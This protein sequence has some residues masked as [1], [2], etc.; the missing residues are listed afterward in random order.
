MSLA[1]THGQFVISEFMANNLSSAEV[2]EDT[3]HSDWIE[4]QNNGPTTASLNGW[5]LTDD[6]TELRKWQFPLTTPAVSV[7]GGGRIT[8][9]ASSK[10]RKASATRLH[11]NFK[12]NNTGEFLALVRPDGTTIEHSYSPAYP[13]QI[14]S[15]TYGLGNVLTTK[16]LLPEISPGRAK[17]P[18]SASDFSLNFNN[19]R[20]ATFDDTSWQAGTA[21]F[22][23]G[24]PFTSQLGS[25]GNI[26]GMM[27]GLNAS[28]FIRYKF[29]YTPTFPVAAMRLIMRWDDGFSS[30]LNG[31]FVLKNGGALI[32]AW[33][34][35]ALSARDDTTSATTLAANTGIP[36]LVSGTNLLGFQLFNSA[37]TEFN[38]SN[39]VTNA[40]L[41]AQLEIDEI[42]SIASGYLSA[43][44]RGAANANL[45]TTIGPAISNTTDKPP[46]PTGGATSA[47]MLITTTVNPT[48]RPLAPSNP[49][50]LRW[51][52]MFATESSVTMMDDGTNGD[53]TA[54]DKIYTASIPTTSLLPGEMIRWRIVAQDNSASPIYAYDPPYPGFSSTA[55][56]TNPPPVDAFMEAE[57]YFGTIALPALVGNTS[58]P[59][60]HWYFT[61][62][63][64]TVNGNGTRCSF[65]WQPLPLDQPPAG[66]VPPKPRFYD[67]VLVNIHGQSSQ[68]FPKKSHDLSFSK[69]N[70]FLWKDGTPET[71]GVNLLSNYADKSKVRDSTAY[72]VWEKSQ[73][74]ASHYATLVRVQQ[75]NAF[76][77]L[78]DLVENGNA[79]WLKR[80]H[81]DEAGTL[82]KIYN[83]LES[84]AGNEKKNPDDT[85][86]T[87]LNALVAGINP[88]LPLTNRL[89][90]LYDNVNVAALINCMATHSI[91]LNRDF[92]HKNYYVYRDTHGTQEWSVLPWDQ[93]LCLGH[94]WTGE[95]G[96]FDDN[97]HSQAALQPIN[98]GVPGNRLM[99]LVYDTPELNH[100]F[101]RRLRTLADHFYV[102]P[103]ETNGPIAQH[104][105]AIIQQIDPDPN[106]TATGLD[107]ADLDSRAWG[108]WVDGSG[109][110]IPYTDSRMAE[111]TA[112]VQ[113]ARITISNPVPPNPGG[114]YNDGTAS[115]FPFLLGRR[116][117]YFSAIPPISPSLNG[118]TLPNQ[119]FPTSQPAEPNV[120][121]EQFNVTPTTGNYQD[122]E[123][124]VI[125]N[126][127]AFAVDLSGW[128]L[129]GDIKLIFQGGTII[130]AQG[131]A[132]TQPENAAYVNEL[133][134]ANQPAGFRTRSTAPMANQYR[135]VAGPYEHQLSAYGGTITLSRP[136][137]PLNPSAGYTQ[138]QSVTYTGVPTDA[139]KY[140]RITELNFRPAPATTQ[141]LAQLPGLVSGDFEFIELLNT[142]EQP[143]DLGGTYF[144]EGVEFTFPKPFLL[145][146][147]QRCVLVASETAF[148]IRYGSSHLVAG[149]F[150][151]ALDNGGETLRLLDSVGEAVLEF[152]YDDDWYPVPT[153]QYRSFVIA[154]PMP[155]ATAYSQPASW[156][157]SANTN[158]S[159]SAGDTTSS[160]VY[161]G[162]RHAF[163][164]N[165]LTN[166]AA[167]PTADP[168]G[169]GWTNFS[170]YAFGSN[171]IDASS[172]PQVRSGSAN[173]GAD[174]F[175]TIT[176]QRPLNTI[177]TVYQGQATSDLANGPWV[178]DAVLLT[179]AVALSNGLE[180]VTFRD[181]ISLTT[182]PT[183]FLRCSCSQ[184]VNP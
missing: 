34:S 14:P 121:L 160:I 37:A 22:G 73:H 25:G 125:R 59:V 87:E 55:L 68:G 169:D 88:S 156:A 96:Y 60:L 146:P 128:K 92:G 69:D 173:I 98:S 181:T 89:K 163:F 112:R 153:G 179:P 124:F 108:F 27:R 49:V 131:A 104:I 1:T 172:V 122:Q 19:W 152:T 83:S 28:C 63:D 12:L 166:P 145:N 53:V 72:W 134:V 42:T 158:G 164:A 132:T 36:F 157:L 184:P 5:Y 3:S 67:N 43:S 79:S 66:Y 99:Q 16:V 177:D 80:Q 65:F 142:G 93:D 105:D 23:F 57:Q 101:V 178:P 127:N 41:K 81:L 32:P 91:I 75:N 30:Y 111:Q 130:P 17:S 167:P 180:E 118:T 39:D 103:A 138:V 26:S 94:T 170:E 90:Y 56:P 133:V 35:V 76:K 11:T 24:S 48:L 61:G 64:N 148:A 97:T 10:N 150:Q 155:A 77:G 58:L 21:G 85:D 4:I 151:G 161:E 110:S 95:Q 71:S 117:Y 100:M 136:N 86:A 176:C 50:T 183:R 115:D 7:P 119:V 165:A 106:N 45:R 2:D 137:D 154:T 33:N 31:N 143:L 13:P 159:P 52:R 109:T 84:T 168:D 47:P 6:A 51:R 147:D 38:G 182:S 129:G 9:W 139:Q 113:A 15:G 18:T 102:A 149:E 8:V 54:N 107:D 70:R 162:W 46:Q 144:E 74:I 82:Y 175:L 123:Y 44:T 20:L 141:E 135:L 140:L 29:N 40:L 171:P 120:I 62:P 78:Y 116:D 174:T 126:P 114:I